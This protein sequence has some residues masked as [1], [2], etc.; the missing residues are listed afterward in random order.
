MWI[1][2]ST[3][4]VYRVPE[5]VAIAEQRV[6]VLLPGICM[7]DLLADVAALVEHPMRGEARLPDATALKQPPP[8][9]P[10]LPRASIGDLP[11]AL[12]TFMQ[13]GHRVMQLVK[14]AVKR[15]TLTCSLLHGGR[16]DAKGPAPAAA[17]RRGRQAEAGNS[18]GT[19]SHD[20][21]RSPA[22]TAGTPAATRG[23]G[24]VHLSP[25]IDFGAREVVRV[26]AGRL[27]QAGSGG[28]QLPSKLLEML[29]STAITGPGAGE[30]SDPGSAPWHLNSN[31]T[32]SATGSAGGP[33]QQA[34]HFNQ[35][36]IVNSS[37]TDQ[38]LLIG[39]MATPTYPHTFSVVDDAGLFLEGGG[40]VYVGGAPCPSVC[41]GG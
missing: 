32:P 11:P 26:D 2:F 22:G 16:E 28:E 13:D 29:S 24:Q 18:S 37:P 7:G 17:A 23:T 8:P 15:A 35:L 14:R 36:T 39:A 20:S 33:A 34:L 5:G 40:W 9:P 19:A 30:V 1:D 27:V 10:P 21:H 31:P 25:D 12:V 6:R 3:E 41:V 4:W 38:C